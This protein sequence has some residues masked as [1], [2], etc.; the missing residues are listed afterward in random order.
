MSTVHHCDVA[1]AVLLALDG[2]MDRRVVNIIDDA[3]PSIYELVALT[4][5]GMATSAEPIADPW[6]MQADGA[7][8]RS[9]SF[10]PAVRTI[11]QAAAQGLL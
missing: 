10:Q 7:P 11:H 9:M 4:V 6:N 1:K 8:A 2:G 3:S 5:K